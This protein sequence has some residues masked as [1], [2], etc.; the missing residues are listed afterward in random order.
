MKKSLI[1]SIVVGFLFLSLGFLLLYYG[2]VGYGLSFFVFLPFVLGYMAGN[3]EVRKIG[4]IGLLISL[5]L[6]LVLLIAGGLEGMGCVLMALPLIL[7]ALALGYWI[8]YL[9]KRHREK[10]K[11]KP[12]VKNSL[13]PLFIFIGA[14]ILEKGLISNEPEIVSVKTEMVFPYSSLEVYETIKS[15]DTLD[16]EKPFLMKIDLP[17]PEKCILEKEEVGGTRT[18]YFSGGTITEKIT[19]LEK[20]KVLRMDVTDY[21]LTGRKWLGFK[22]AIYY[23]DAVGKDSCRLTRITTYT[24]ELKPRFYWEPLEKLGIQQEHDY[25]FANL[26]KDLKRKYP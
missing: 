8:H 13:W 1:L 18:C 12:S 9:G 22:E 23:F 15:V 21:Q 26:L 2:L 6:F 10:Q 3:A 25:V 16:A 7:G 4:L 5:G 19:E 14:G 11:D 20:A 24:S 17:V